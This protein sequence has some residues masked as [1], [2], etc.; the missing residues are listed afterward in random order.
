MKI[1]LLSAAIAA[2]LAGA[3]SAQVMPT[4]GAGAAPVGG[5]GIVG[6]GCPLPTSDPSNAG[7]Q[8]TV[9]SPAGAS[10][11]SPTRGVGV[12]NCTAGG[13]IVLKTPSGNMN[14]TVPVTPYADRPIQTL[15]IVSSTATCGAYYGLN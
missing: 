7:Y 3:A 13:L 15:G 14:W 2:A 10:L 6:P 4:A 12:D 1:L 8:P 9:L 5:C 11:S